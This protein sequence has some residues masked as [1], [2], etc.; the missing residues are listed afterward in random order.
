MTGLHECCVVVG[1][2][3]QMTV[4]LAQAGISHSSEPSSHMVSSQ[5]P[6]RNPNS[7][8]LTNT[9]KGFHYGGLCSVL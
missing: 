3:G 6:R 8:I 7:V 4:P 1:L 5:A 9:P 2:G